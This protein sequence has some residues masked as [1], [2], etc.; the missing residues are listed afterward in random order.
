MAELLNR[1]ER[2]HNTETS[3]TEVLHTQ[4]SAQ[5]MTLHRDIKTNP[6]T[7]WIAVHVNRFNDF[8]WPQLMA[9]AKFY[10]LHS[11]LSNNG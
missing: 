6:Y 1:N 4:R 5:L 11:Q 10:H 3:Q 9:L 8:I 2:Y 7:L